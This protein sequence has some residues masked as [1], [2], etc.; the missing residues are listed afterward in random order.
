MFASPIPAARGHDADLSDRS[1]T[2]LAGKHGTQACKQLAVDGKLL[3]HSAS[4]VSYIW[5]IW[6]H[7]LMWIIIFN[8][9]ATNYSKSL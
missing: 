4:E 5:K 2:P 3:S 6:K 8:T 7:L 9:T 1:V